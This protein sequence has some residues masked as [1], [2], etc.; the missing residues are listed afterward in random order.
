MRPRS[1]LYPFRLTMTF[2]VK[3][4]RLEAPLLSRLTGG[5]RPDES[6]K[7]SVHEKEKPE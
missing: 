7:P 6:E 1:P 5:E 3:G 4:L 2:G